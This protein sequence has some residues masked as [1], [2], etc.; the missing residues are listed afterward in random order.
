[1]R[2][3][4]FGA[5]LLA[6]AVSQAGWQRAH[7]QAAG[8]PGAQPAGGVKG[9]EEVI[10]TASKRS[11]RLQR[12]PLSVEVLDTK[13]LQRLHVDNFQDYLKFLPSLTAQTVGPDQTTLYMR[14]IASGAEGNHSGPLPTVGSYLDELPI[15]TIGG[16]LDVHVYDIARVE[17]LPGPQ[18]TLYGAS[19]E[20]GTIRIITNRPNTAK[21]EAGYDLE[22]NVV[23]HGGLGGVAEGFVNIPITNNIAV[24]LVAF[25]EHDAGFIDNVSG[26]RTFPTAA[27]LYGDAAATVNDAPLVRN[28][29]NPVDTFGGRAA[30]RI[31]LNDSW[32]ITPNVVVQDTRSNGIQGYVASDGD[33]NVQRFQPD[34]F[35]DRW[36]QAGA[37][38]Q[39]KIGDFDLTYAGGFFVRDQVQ[40][41]DYTDYS[42]FYDQAYGS[43]A[44]WQNAAGQ[45]LPR[46][47]QEIDGKDHYTKESNEIRLASPASDRLRF[48][49]GAF[50]EIQQHRIIQDYQIQGFGPQISVP[51]WPNTIWL[52]NQLRTDRDEAVFGELSYDILPNLTVTGGVRPY[53]Y[54]NS[55]KGFFGFSQGYD[56]LT[57]FNSGAGSTGQHCIPGDTFE[58]TTCVDLDKDTTGHGETHK[59]NASYKIDA[60]KLVYFTYSTGYRPGGINRNANY[61]AYQA[62]SL[63]NFELGFK[64]SWFQQTLHANVTLY[65][66][67]WNLFQYAFLGPNSLTIIGNAPGANVKGA[68]FTADYRATNQLSFFGGFTITDAEL[69]QNLCLHVG[70][71]C[72][73][74]QAQ[75]PAGTQ[76]PYTS[77]FKGNLTTRYTFDVADWASFV[78]GSLVYQTAQQAA[79]LLQDANGQNEKAVLGTMTPYATLD[80][81]AGIERNRLS[82]SLFV[83]NATDRRGELDRAVTCTIGICSTVYSFPIRPLTVGF[84]VSQRF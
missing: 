57:G 4:V 1:M 33:L 77:R 22:G 13:A 12:I 39:G 24:R 18:G 68:E 79:L 27:S 45:P 75:A 11:E 58:E 26:T 36:I 28:N 23:D 54:D 9:I 48:I 47:L 78:Q 16:T 30:L 67:D 72:T 35:H 82:I 74:A 32:S 60:D 14:G 53:W 8:S 49:V 65:D 25:D 70:E 44:N 34:T 64:S 66:E 29:F 41:S 80:F 71:T 40:K 31:D 21:F 63:T 59:I 56:A 84:Q 42:I 81:S 46:P 5:S 38:V 19:S 43:G 3:R 62:D 2:T 50:Q 69:S 15:T 83:K 37:T 76:L 51:G 55:L 61:G 7:A 6:I 20:A 73:A 52:T 10:V 17:V